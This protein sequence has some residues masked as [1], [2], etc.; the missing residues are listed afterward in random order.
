MRIFDAAEIFVSLYSY[1]LPPQSSEILSTHTHSAL[2]YLHQDCMYTSCLPI[3]MAEGCVGLKGSRAARA[4]VSDRK[5]QK[6]S[7]LL[8]EFWRKG[9]AILVMS[10]LRKK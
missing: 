9:T 5:I 4:R 3:G 2:R 10:Y 7:P 6:I 1:T 8:R